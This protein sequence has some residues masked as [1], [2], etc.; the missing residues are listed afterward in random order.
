MYDAYWYLSV[1]KFVDLLKIV[2]TNII[3]KQNPSAIRV[4]LCPLAD[5]LVACWQAPVEA[6][7]AALDVGAHAALDNAFP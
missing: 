3:Q 4:L 7:Y 6:V 1:W 2:A 5:P